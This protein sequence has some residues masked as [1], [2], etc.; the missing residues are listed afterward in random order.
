[1]HIVSHSLCAPQVADIA[2]LPSGMKASLMLWLVILF[3][4][5]EKLV[6]PPAAC[7]TADTSDRCEGPVLDQVD[8]SGASVRD[9]PTSAAGKQDGF[10]DG[11]GTLILGQTV[12]GTQLRLQTVAVDTMLLKPSSSDHAGGAAACSRPGDKSSQRGDAARFGAASSPG[13]RA[14][15]ESQPPGMVRNVSEVLV[16]SSP[17]PAMSDGGGEGPPRGYLHD[18]FSPTNPSPLPRP[19]WTSVSTS[20]GTASTPNPPRHFGDMISNDGTEGRGSS[21]GREGAIG[22]GDVWQGEAAGCAAASRHAGATPGVGIRAALAQGREFAVE[23]VDH[24]DDDEEEEEEEEDMYSDTAGGGWGDSPSRTV[25]NEGER[26]RAALPALSQGSSGAGRVSW[27]VDLCGEKHG[28]NTRGVREREGVA[29]DAGMRGRMSGGRADEFVDE[30]VS[31]ATGA[32]AGGKADEWE[33]ELPRSSSPVAYTGE[34]CVR[35]RVRGFV[36]VCVCARA[37]VRACLCSGCRYWS[38]SVDPFHHLTISPPSLPSPSR[39]GK[40]YPG[41]P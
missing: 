31:G 19:S 16:L 36:C 39:P 17:S 40:P 23:E 30:F 18:G 13:S 32:H 33:E 4:N 10:A 12:G 34:L 3:V 11:A 26:S 25:E 7:P 14:S 20:S 2:Y 6:P 22:G 29:V 15:E 5:L 1:V 21:A 28:N 35:A 8:P 27:Q 24:D 38:S 37:R 41:K 9:S